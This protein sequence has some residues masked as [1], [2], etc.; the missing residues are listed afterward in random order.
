MIGGMV[1]SLENLDYPKDRLEA[2]ILVERRDTATKQ[3][4]AAVVPAPFIR[5]WKSRRASRRPSRGPATPGC[6]WPRAT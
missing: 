5:I 3:A 1:R 4:I 6:C 2:L